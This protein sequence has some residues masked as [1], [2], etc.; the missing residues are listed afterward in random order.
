MR[1]SSLG[2]V[3]FNVEI[4]KEMAIKLNKLTQNQYRRPYSLM[5]QMMDDHMDVNGIPLIN[6]M[7]KFAVSELGCDR[8]TV[9]CELEIELT[10]LTRSFLTKFVDLSIGDDSRNFLFAEDRDGNLSCHA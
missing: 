7:A 4:R 6:L 5:R 3:P 1:S 10:E 8:E 2:L 9:V